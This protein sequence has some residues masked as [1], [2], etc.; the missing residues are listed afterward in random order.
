MRDALAKLKSI[1]KLLQQRR[2][3]KLW[4]LEA[5]DDVPIRAYAAL[6]KGQFCRHRH[7]V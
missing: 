7:T 2:N 3:K 1:E 5:A 4:Q 6:S